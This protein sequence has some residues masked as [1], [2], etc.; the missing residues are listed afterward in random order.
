[1]FGSE[2]REYSVG[3]VV[4]VLCDVEDCVESELDRLD[5]ISFVEFELVAS[6]SDR[7][8]MG[9]EKEDRPLL[10]F[11]IVVVA[12]DLALIVTFS[13]LSLLSPSS[14]V[15]ALAPNSSP[16]DLDRFFIYCNDSSLGRLDLSSADSVPEE[17][18]EEWVVAEESRREDW[19]A[20]GR[21]DDRLLSLLLRKLIAS[22]TSSSR[23]SNTGVAESL[24]EGGT[25]GEEELVGGSGLENPELRRLD[26]RGR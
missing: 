1:M 14:L 16:I 7:L 13:S 24:G 5:L 20:E 18:M 8:G 11:D 23:S 25:E 21:R 19:N 12:P 22:S 17:S 3:S 9:M 6:A 2:E 26:L 4:P 15:P 10:E